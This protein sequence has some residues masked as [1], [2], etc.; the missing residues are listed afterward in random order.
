[1]NFS[2]RERFTANGFLVMTHS[3]VDAAG[4][5]F[6]KAIGVSDE[7]PAMLNLAKS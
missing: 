5:D 7:A 2:D 4:N 6:A 3:F 1:M